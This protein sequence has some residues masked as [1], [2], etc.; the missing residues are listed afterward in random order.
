MS[1]DSHLG[2]IL[3]VATRLVNAVVEGEERGRPFEAPPT[4]GLRGA[5]ADALGGG[6]RPKPRLTQADAVLLARTAAQLH[7]VFSMVQAGQERE[8]AWAV[9]ELLARFGTR[10]QLDPDGYGGFQLHFHGFDDSLAIGW[11]AGLAAGLAVVIGSDLAGRLGVCA[12][13]SCDRVYVDT[14][15]NNQ[16]RFCGTACQNRVKA[17]TFRHRRGPAS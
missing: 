14:S 4:T 8:A 3:D 7:A 17:A 6:D 9:N 11:S 16:K 13:P 15:R 1:F 10:P 12:A 2:N 5:V